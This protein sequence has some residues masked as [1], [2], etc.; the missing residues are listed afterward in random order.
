M[1]AHP[2]QDRIRMA[3]PVRRTGRVRRIRATHVEADGPALP[4]GA[5]C[6]IA[7]QRSDGP[8]PILAEVVRVDR[9]SISLVPFEDGASTFPGAE[10]VALP[11]SQHVAVGDA[12][13]GRAVDALGRAIDEGMNPK[14][15]T[16]APLHGETVSPLDRASP[17]QMLPTGIRAIDGLLTLARGQRVGIFAAAG[18]GKTSLITQ[19]AA[20][21]DADVVVLV[22][23][24]ERG[25]EVEALWSGLPSSIRNRTSLVAAT[26]DQPA[27]SRVRAGH[28]AMALAEHWRKQGKQVLLLLD[29][30]TR[31]AMA[32][33]EIGLAAGEPPTV[34]AYT[35][36]VFAAIP[37]LIE[38]AGAM[39]AGGSISAVMTVLSETD[40][41]DDP[42]SEMMKSLLDGHIILSRTLAEQGH[43]P[44]IDVSRSVSR[45]A[46][47]LRSPE[48]AVHV[49]QVA[50]WISA[51]EQSRAMRQAGLYASGSDALIDEAIAR[52]ASITAFLRQGSTEASSPEKSYALLE[53]L[54]GVHG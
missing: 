41:V 29:S 32:M 15:T 47:A 1:M 25:R 17:R 36:N 34:R 9:E 50:A 22:L 37:R 8:A 28:Y 18:V 46:E 42:I 43:F 52:H 13:L 39:R 51:Y 44:A 20:Q 7:G 19:L 38:R 54:Q 21:V 23:V 53:A 4:L 49:R 30:V 16:L 14:G 48:Q 3:D 12:F 45:Q 35:P 5:H 24:G 26:S 2:W 11:A 10:V 6:R 31:L 27:M 33:R 40:D